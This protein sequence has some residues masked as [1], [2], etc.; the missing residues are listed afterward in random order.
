M[1]TLTAV[2]PPTRRAAELTIADLHQRF[3]PMRLNRLRFNPWPGTA[4]EQDVLDIR[5]RESRLYELIDGIL[6]E[7]AMG[8]PESILAM[9]IGAALKV[10]ANLHK[11][12]AVLGAD[13]M[14]RLAPGLVRIPDVSY[15]PWD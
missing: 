6:L 9:A 15:I 12:G 5:A 2:P 13:G 4:T 14:M 10:F 7:K 1:S 11:S 8:F 3:G